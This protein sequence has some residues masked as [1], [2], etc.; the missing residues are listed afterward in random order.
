MSD[1]LF[2][3][4][5][6]NS[7]R[8]IYTPSG[9]AKSSLLHIQEIG[10]LQA[11]SRHASRRE[12]LES[13]LFFLVQSGSGLLFYD[14]EEYP[15]KAGDCVFI[16]CKKPYYHMT[17]EDLWKL[18]WVHF[19]G[20]TLPEIYNKYIERGGNPSFHPDNL[21]SYLEIC[22]NL[23]ETATKDSYVRDMEINGDLSKLLILLMADAW[24]PEEVRTSYKKYD[25]NAIRK[26]LDDNHQKKISLD[27][28]SEKF[29]IN[30]YYLTRIFK[31]QFGMSINDYLLSVRITQAK[32]LLR[33]SD[34]TAEE[35]GLE[36]GIGPGYYFS[37]VFRSV[38]GVGPSEY[39]R[40]WKSK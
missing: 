36:T 19:N 3:G 15:L 31:E 21:L 34:K 27:E 12:N 20:P 16:D 38:E 35:I 5:L 40:N 24:N 23:Q 18:T 8:V 10:T 7:S 13:Y 2:H 1:A 4:D 6:V 25:L 28:L 29:F 37:R 33:F 26:Y 11:T 14:G 9:F 39:R 17:S 30:K 22:A 32:S